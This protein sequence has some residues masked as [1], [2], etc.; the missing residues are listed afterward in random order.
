MSTYSTATGAEDLPLLSVETLYSHNHRWLFAI[1]HRRLG[2]AA[3]A[4]DLAQDAF[5][6]LLNKPKPF[7]NERGAR[8]Y[9]GSIAR[10]M[11]IDLWRRREV[12]QAW[13]D[14]LAAQPDSVVPSSEQQA[15]VIQALTEVQALLQSLPDNVAAAFIKTMVYGMTG[16]E[17]AAEL[18]VSE[19]TI[20][21]YLS[22]A[23][24]ECII[25]EARRTSQDV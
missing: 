25:F 5:L 18:N 11:C 4:A 13:L 7:N 22:H 2:N 24:L 6:R 9:L 1:L 14:T 16:K 21:S 17:V 8:A 10:G 19:R 12:E 3:D 20:R 15:I 23:M